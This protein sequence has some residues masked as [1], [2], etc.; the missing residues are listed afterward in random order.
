[1]PALNLAINQNT[2]MGDISKH[3]NRAEFAC[4]DG[5]GFSTVDA[6]LI[7]VLEDV[8]ERFDGRVRVTSG[9]RCPAHN[10]RVG[11]AADSEHTRGTAA[12]IIVD[13]VSAAVVYDYLT[14]KYPG[15]YG[16]GK[17]TTWTHI[18]VRPRFARWI[19]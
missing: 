19:K 18:D 4:G 9:C 14:N 16:I 3:F 7:G 8:R 12:D 11:G 1:M 2:T 6:E 5:C 17:Y 15:R 10:R 13:G